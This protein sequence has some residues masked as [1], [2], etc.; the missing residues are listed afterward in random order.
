VRSGIYFVKI[1]D[2]KREF[3]GSELRDGASG[4]PKK[5]TTCSLC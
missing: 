5:Q 2:E 3:I 1:I 4:V